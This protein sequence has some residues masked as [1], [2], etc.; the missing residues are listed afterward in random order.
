MLQVLKKALLIV[1]GE[2]HACCLSLVLPTVAK[3]TVKAGTVFIS[4]HLASP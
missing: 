4:I 2:K 3:G 1:G